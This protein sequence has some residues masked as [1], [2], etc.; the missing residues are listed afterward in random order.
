MFVSGRTGGAQL[1]VLDVDSRRTLAD[2]RGDKAYLYPRWSPDG[3]HIAA[4]YGD[5]EN[6]DIIVLDDIANPADLPPPPAPGT[7]PPAP[8]A[9]A[10]PPPAAKPPAPGTAV[11]PPPPS[12]PPAIERALTAWSYDDLSPT[13]SPDGKRIAFY[14]NYNPENDPKVWSI[15]VLESD[16]SV[17]ASEPELIARVVARNVIPDVAAGPAWLPDSRRIA[18]VGN[19]K[20]DYNPIY[21]VDVDS[22]LSQRLKTDTSIN[23]DLTV[24]PKGMI[25]FRAQVEQWDRVFL[26]RL[27]N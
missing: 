15:V 5:N 16:R 14:S 19:D 4:I 2:P 10:A 22:R 9:A 27:A 17:P 6:H 3:K 18:Y 1:F 8:G 26:A 21:I 7:T 13:W 11:A 23:R 24:S 20:N 12:P 25:A